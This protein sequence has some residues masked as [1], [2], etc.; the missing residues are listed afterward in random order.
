MSCE[1]LGM[2]LTNIQTVIRSNKSSVTVYVYNWLYPTVAPWYDHH[3][4]L[5]IKEL[6]PVCLSIKYYVCL[7]FA[8]TNNPVKWH[9]NSLS[10][11]SNIRRSTF[12]VS[13]DSGL[14]FTLSQHTSPAFCMAF[15][16][17][18][19]AVVSH[20]VLPGGS[21]ELRVFSMTLRLFNSFPVATWRF[22]FVLF[23][24]CCTMHF[25]FQLK[26]RMEKK[27]VFYYCMVLC[28]M[29]LVWYLSN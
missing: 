6:I 29:C 7:W 2:S 26:V 23:L 27:G 15:R 19:S 9:N 5:G 17:C 21:S 24:Y 8:S 14:A 25:A 10:I 13:S 22:C 12:R 28:Q 1:A 16:Y 11:N 18:R 20:S 3:G 4:W